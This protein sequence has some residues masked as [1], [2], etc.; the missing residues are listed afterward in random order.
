MKKVSAFFFFFFLSLV[1]FRLFSSSICSGK[2]RN[3]SC[4]MRGCYIVEGNQLYISS[5]LNK[6]GGGCGAATA[7]VILQRFGLFKGMFAEAFGGNVG[8]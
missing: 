3:F 1:A 6:V 7:I 2:E 5:D 8:A 4:E